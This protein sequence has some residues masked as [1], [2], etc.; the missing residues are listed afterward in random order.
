MIGLSFEITC[1][2]CGSADVVIASGIDDCDHIQIA[3]VCRGCEN[4]EEKF[5]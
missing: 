3:L 2:K 1:K 4:T 5:E